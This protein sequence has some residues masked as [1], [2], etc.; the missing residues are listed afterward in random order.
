[1]TLTQKTP[2]A[3]K[4]GTTDVSKVY[5][6]TTL[7]RQKIVDWDIDFLIVGWWWAWWSNYYDGSNSYSTTWWWWAWGFVECSNVTLPKGSYNVVVGCGGVWCPLNCANWWNGWNSSFNGVVAYWGWGWWW[8]CKVW[9]NWASWWWG[10]CTK[11]WWSWCQWYSWGTAWTKWW[12]WWWAWWAGAS[13]DNEGVWGIWKYSEISWE[14]CWYAWW[15]GWV[16]WKTAE[17]CNCGTMYCWWW[18]R[19]NYTAG[20]ECA[21]RSVGTEW[22]PWVVIIRYPTN[23]W[24]ATWGTMVTC[25]WYNIHTFTSNGTFSY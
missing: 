23:C 24:T 10:G 16:A 18:G 7:I 3:I 25:N 13:W 22:Q 2:T 19:G 15:G 1:M 20:G 17:C 4:V 14:W 12:G 5:L 11:S 9:S 6:G 21:C 8:Y